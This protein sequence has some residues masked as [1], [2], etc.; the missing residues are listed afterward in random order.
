MKEELTAMAPILEKSQAAAAE[1]MIVLAKEQTQAAK[2]RATV[3]VDE[4]AAKV[5]IE[6]WSV[7]TTIISSLLFL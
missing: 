5:R 2:V 3:E 7:V 4:A 6:T 1:L